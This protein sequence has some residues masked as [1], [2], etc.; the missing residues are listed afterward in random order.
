MHAIFWSRVKNSSGHEVA[1]VRL[2]EGKLEIDERNEGLPQL[3]VDE[4]EGSFKRFPTEV[5]FF[6]HVQRDYRG[7]RVWAK[8]VR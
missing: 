1:T 2:V 6:S 4:L 3:V 8:V 7:S 5:L